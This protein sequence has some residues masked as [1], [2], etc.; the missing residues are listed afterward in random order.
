MLRGK[1]EFEVHIPTFFKYTRET[2]NRHKGKTEIPPKYRGTHQLKF[3]IHSNAPMYWLDEEDRGWDGR[4]EIDWHW[5][6]PVWVPRISKQD[7]GGGE[8]KWY[9]VH[10]DW[11]YYWGHIELHPADKGSLPL[12]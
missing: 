7:L 6:K 2:W 4:D 10:F 3:F 9:K 12:L 11:L 5:R 1:L 8:F